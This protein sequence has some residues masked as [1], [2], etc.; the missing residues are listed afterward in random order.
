MARGGVRTNLCVRDRFAWSIHPR[1]NESLQFPRSISAIFYGWVRTCY[2]LEVNNT[3]LLKA[4]VMN[5][6][7]LGL[8]SSRPESSRPGSSRPGPILSLVGMC[9]LKGRIH[10]KLEEGC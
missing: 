2:L 8:G 1:Y 10:K 6:G 5:A 9:L 7:Q 4:K 3:L